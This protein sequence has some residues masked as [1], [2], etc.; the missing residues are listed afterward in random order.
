VKTK[1]KK[2]HA[3]N[4]VLQVAALVSLVRRLG[5]R[6]AGRLAVA[7]ASALLKQR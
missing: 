2:L 7:T 5:P 6:R 1:H 4:T 3:L